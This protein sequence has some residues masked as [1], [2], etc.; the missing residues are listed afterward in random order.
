MIRLLVCIAA[1]AA[2]IGANAQLISGEFIPSS[3]EGALGPLALES[4]TTSP[5]GMANVTGGDEPDIFVSSGRWGPGPGF[6]LYAFVGRGERGEPIFGKPERIGHPFER[7]YPPPGTI[8]QTEDGVVHALWLS[9]GNAVHC[10]FNADER[11]FVKQNEIAIEGTPRRPSDLGV[12]IHE[13]A[14]ATLLLSVSDGTS[15]RN[16]KG[17]TR[18]PEYDPYDGRGIWRGGMPYVAMYGVDIPTLFEGPA[19]TARLLSPTEQEV[20]VQYAGFSEARLGNERGVITGSRFGM[21][22]YYPFGETMDRLSRHLHIVDSDGI[23]LRHPSIH[24]TPIAYP[25]PT[26]GDSDIIAGG[27]GGLYWYRFTGGFNDAQKPIFD[28]PIP[29]LETSANLYA[30]SLPVTNCVDWD[31]DGAA[32]LVVGNSEGFVL[33][34]ENRGDYDVPAF[35]PGV[36]LEA[37]GRAIHIQP[38]YRLDIQGPNEARWGY[39]CPTVVDW[40]SDGDLDIVSSDSTARHMLFENTGT[41]TE[42]KLEAAVPI[43]YDGLELFGTWRVQPAVGEIDGR[44]AYI[45]LDDDDE[46]HLYWQVDKRNVTSGGKLRLENGNVVGANFL[47]GGGTGRLKI[48]LYD[49]ND[50]GLQDLIVGTPR[51]GSVPDPENGLPQSLGLPGS[52]VLYLEN[53]GER[54]S[55]TFAFPKLFAFKGKPIHLGQ[56]A[57]GPCVA[58]FGNG[59][60]GL[61]VGEESGRLE[62]FAREHLTTLTK[63]EIEEGR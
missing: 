56:H 26:T 7:D 47:Q 32:D 23:A 58:D 33:F 57:C 34:F 30:G 49:W 14:K 51:H 19:T 31:G 28:D 24:P 48:R 60:P 9:G 8:V 3:R 15:Y 42:P 55:P 36:Q 27:E 46:F 63:R 1:L 17:S 35:L 38:G 37:G 62:Y 41:R 5:V 25:N 4:V 18:D 40:D 16:W 10:V 39:V 52:S 20:R 13:D 11:A 2:S 43:Y 29:V 6:F 22:H 54:G 12:V 45:A 61:I 50:D 21:L 44:M 59:A 53:V